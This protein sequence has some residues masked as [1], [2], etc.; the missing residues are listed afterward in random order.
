MEDNDKLRDKWIPRF[1]SLLAYVACVF[2]LVIR[3]STSDFP[4]KM[5]VILDEKAVQLFIVIG[6][7][8]AMSGAMII[9]YYLA[10]NLYGLDHFMIGFDARD[11]DWRY[12]TP[13]F[14]TILFVLLLELVIF[15]HNS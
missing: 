1:H 2:Y 4:A 10:K 14:Y 5:H 15:F 9:A 8:L 7:F 6:A 11:N 13:Y 3:Q 12:C